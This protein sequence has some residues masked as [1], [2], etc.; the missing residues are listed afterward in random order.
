MPHVVLLTDSPLHEVVDGLEPFVVK[1]E[2]TVW[3]LRDTFLDRR[4]VHALCECLIVRRGRIERFFVQLSQ[5]EE[6]A[7][8][9]ARPHRVPRVEPTP[10]VKR[11]VALVAEAAER[12][13]PDVRI[14][15]STVRDFLSDRWTF[16]PDPDPAGW[17]PLLPSH[18]M[19]RPLDWGAVFGG[20]GPVEIE[21]GSGK[22]TFLVET[23]EANPDVRYVS[24]EW[25]RAYA[26][27]VRDRARRRE[28]K[29]VRVVQADAAAFVAEH[30]PAG[31]L[32]TIHIYFPDP[33]PKERHHHR[34]LVQPPFVEAAADALEPGGELRFVTD[35]E[36]YFEEAVERLAAEPR[37][38]RCEFPEEATPFTNYLRKY[39][40][41][42]RPIHRALFVLTN[43]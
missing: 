36:E 41:E 19:P 4:G 16:T 25:A 11:M 35:H 42:G 39:R 5:R 24:V 26:H 43:V 40:E 32:R 27:H 13:H 38:E 8:V 22:G 3:K 31:S 21:I 20:E 17:D 1:E 34:R 14:A 12:G 23:A 2:G 28:L 15:R 18:G 29:N 10:S 9:V 33:W 30:V 6:D 37:L 7:A